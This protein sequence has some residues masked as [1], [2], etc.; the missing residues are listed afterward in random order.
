MT[1]FAAL[2]FFTVCSMIVFL[3]MFVYTLQFFH[4]SS[5]D[6][7]LQAPCM[8][9]GSETSISGFGG[10]ELLSGEQSM[11]AFSARG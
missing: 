4:Y 10:Q 3:D 8:K 11:H 2:H 7:L 5:T 1:L 6:F 9:I